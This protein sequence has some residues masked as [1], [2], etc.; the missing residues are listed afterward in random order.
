[1]ATKAELLQRV[2]REYRQRTGKAEVDH[3]EVAKF[4]IDTLGWEAPEPKDKY[5]LLAK[6]ISEAAR[7]EERHDKATGE[8]YR[9]NLSYSVQQGATQ[10]RLWVDTDEANRFQMD[11]CKTGCR[12]QVAGE[13][14]RMANTFDHWNRV[15]PDEQPVQFDLDFGPDILWARNAPGDADKKAG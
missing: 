4:A 7:L 2:R 9:A 3:R 8:N 10:T 5:D 13:I 11:R 1:M 12:G 15:H 6:D 14:L